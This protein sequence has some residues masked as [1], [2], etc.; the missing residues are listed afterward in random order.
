MQKLH[1]VGVAVNDIDGAIKTYSSIPGLG[2]AA[3]RHLRIMP[4]FGVKSVVISSSDYHSVTVELMEPLP[5]TKVRFGVSV[6]E[7]LTN[8]G[9]GIFYF[10]ILT[11]T[12]DADVKAAQ[13]M[14]FSVIEESYNTLFNGYETRLAWL[15][16]ED[17][18]GAWI[19]YIDAESIPPER[20]G[21]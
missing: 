11:D 9:E 17:T 3:G 21:W 10:A 18:F 14:G 1:H 2:I 20:R 8:K 13:D 6:A 16:P 7:Y 4:E 15:Q 5:D 19:D 12:F